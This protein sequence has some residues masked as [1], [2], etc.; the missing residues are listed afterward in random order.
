LTLKWTKTQADWSTKG[1]PLS[2]KIQR[3]GDGR[4]NWQISRDDQPNPMASGVANSLGAAKNVVEQ[5][6]NRSGLV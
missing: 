2:A 4:W 3:K 1:G 5:F 6:V